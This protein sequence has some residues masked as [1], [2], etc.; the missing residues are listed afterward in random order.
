[1]KKLLSII[2]TFCIISIGCEETFQPIKKNDKYN[3]SMYGYL[4]ASTDTQW[5]RITPARRQISVPEIPEMQVTLVETAT[6]NSAVMNDSLL[7]LAN[8][9]QFVSVWTTM[10]VKPE[11]TYRLEAEQPDGDSSSV[12]VTIPED[13]PTPYL[14]YQDGM[15]NGA[16]LYIEDVPRLADARSTWFLKMNSSGYIRHIVY[17]K[18]YRNNITPDSPGNYDFYIPP[19]EPIRLPAGDIDRARRE[20]FVASGGPEWNEKL[21]SIDNLIYALP[22]GFSNVKNGVGY[23]IGIVSKTI[24][25]ERHYVFEGQSLV[26]CHEE[27]PETQMDSRG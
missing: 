24:P 20:I 1:M 23:V 22:D 5:V 25:Y 9:I 8:G 19:Y 6:G 10:N 27:P 2:A 17:H 15:C 14:V 21:V 7:Q 26:A 11:H 16:R 13:F 12:T 18:P 3:F 4:D